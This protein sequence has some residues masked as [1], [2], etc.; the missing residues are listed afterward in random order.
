M[1]QRMRATGA[2]W[3]VIGTVLGI[4]R[5]SAWERFRHICAS[6]K[7]IPEALLQA[8]HLQ[9]DAFDK[10]VTEAVKRDMQVKQWL[11]TPNA[12]LSAAR[13]YRAAVPP[14]NL[15]GTPALRIFLMVAA[16][17]SAAPV[18]S[19]ES[20][21]CPICGRSYLDDDYLSRH[22]TRDHPAIGREVTIQ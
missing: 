15:L 13:G 20:V 10:W 11:E 1:V 4:T 18:S 22:K 19:P 9:P 5:Q 2:S 7:N 8:R 21:S 12:D 17:D 3:Q 16:H 6:R 14:I